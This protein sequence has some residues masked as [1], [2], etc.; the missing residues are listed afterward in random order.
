MTNPTSSTT[1]T[2]IYSQSIQLITVDLEASQHAQTVT[3]VYV[4]Y[5][6]ENLETGIRVEDIRVVPLKPISSTTVFTAY[7]QLAEQQVMSWVNEQL[8]WQ[9]VK[10]W[11]DLEL[12]LRVQLQKARVLVFSTTTQVCIPPWT[13]PETAD[14]TLLATLEDGRVTTEL[15]FD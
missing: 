2:T 14:V 11:M 10:Q 3:H 15:I 13:P 7:E 4:K 8:P 1:T 12:D 5:R 9:Q 6:A